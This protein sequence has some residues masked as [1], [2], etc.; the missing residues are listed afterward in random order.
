MSGI[1]HSFDD[2]G[3]LLN[4]VPRGPEPVKVFDSFFFWRI[5]VPFLKLHK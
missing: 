1:N 4:I 5:G 3:K 2:I